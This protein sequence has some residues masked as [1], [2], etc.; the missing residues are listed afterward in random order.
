[1]RG[2]RGELGAHEPRYGVLSMSLLTTNV[3]ALFAFAEREL[4]IYVYPITTAGWTDEHSMLP[5]VEKAL[6]N[7]SAAPADL[8]RSRQTYSAGL[9]F[10]RRLLLSSM[11]TLDA[12]R[13]DLFFVPQWEGLLGDFGRG[14]SG[15]YLS[16]RP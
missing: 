14:I 9:R 11:R 4:R 16:C 12:S 6:H 15:G 13:A 2:G 5:F 8:S 1:M 3:S 7:I 10:L